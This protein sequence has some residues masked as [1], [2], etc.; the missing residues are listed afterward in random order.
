MTRPIHVIAEPSMRV[1]DEWTRTSGGWIGRR[2]KRGRRV[3]E[4]SLCFIVQLGNHEIHR[5]LHEQFALTCHTTCTILGELRSR[6]TDAGAVAAVRSKR[7]PGLL[8]SAG[9]GSGRGRPA[10]AQDQR[11][12]GAG[13]GVA[14]LRGD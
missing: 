1:P 10:G 13:A 6:E 5:D 3:F 9:T 11:V 14:E 4:S 7:Q 12:D 8:A 2:T